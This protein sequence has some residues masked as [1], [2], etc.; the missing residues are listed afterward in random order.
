MY[1]SHK[2]ELIKGVYADNLGGG[3]EGEGSGAH[4]SHTHVGGV[5]GYDLF[6]HFGLNREAFGQN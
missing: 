3:Y 6:A 1:T 4:T 5:Y 2:Q